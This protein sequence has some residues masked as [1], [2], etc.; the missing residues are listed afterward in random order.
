MECPRNCERLFH[1]VAWTCIL[2]TMVQC[3][4]GKGHMKGMVDGKLA[5][6]PD[7]PNCV[8][9]QSEDVSH[10]VEPLPYA[11]P[12]Q[13]ARRDLLEI[14]KSMTGAKVVTET[15]YYIHATFTSR[16]FRFVDDVEFYLPRDASVIHVRSASRTGY[17][18]FGVNRR[19]VE[20]IR[21]ALSSPR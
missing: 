2:L 1:T 20:K 5:P 17:F 7:S 21:K 19:R 18:D 6:C 11:G 12:M 16:I 8:S 9:S 3:T 10:F 4:P 13:A 14:V 15:L